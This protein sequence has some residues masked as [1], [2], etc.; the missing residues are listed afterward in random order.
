[1]QPLNQWLLPKWSISTSEERLLIRCEEPFRACSNALW[2]GGFYQGYGILN[3]R[4]DHDY[5]SSDPLADIQRRIEE[6]GEEPE[7]FIGM[8]TAAQVSAAG[9]ACLQGDQFRLCAVVT[10]GVGNAVR[11]GQAQKTYSAYRADTINTIVML[12]ANLTDSAVVN[13]LVTATEAKTAALQDAGV[14][15]A[16]G[17]TATGTSTDVVVIAAR[18]ID[19]NLPTHQYAGTATSL[20]DSL[21]KS[22]YTATVTAVEQERIRGRRRETHR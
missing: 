1:M 2:N 12:D 10:A 17:R 3:Q 20:G 9:T 19:G 11:A 16:L 7:K 13:A 22:V 5:H 8:L 14:M 21:A 18:R 6:L 4:V 15:D